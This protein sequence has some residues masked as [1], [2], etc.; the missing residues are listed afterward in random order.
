MGKMLLLLQSTNS[1]V[2]EIILDIAWYW[3]NWLYFAIVYHLLR[4]KGL[5]NCK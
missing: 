5:Q 2:F 1:I 4:P 3:Y